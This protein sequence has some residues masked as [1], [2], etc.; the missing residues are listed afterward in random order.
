MSKKLIKLL[1]FFIIPFLVALKTYGVSYDTA[2]SVPFPA[3]I[4]T[5]GDIVS[6][7]N[8]EY[9]LTEIPY[10]PMMVGVIVEDPEVALE[11]RNL[12]NYQFISSYGEVL[13]NVKGDIS[14]GN[15]VTSS[16]IAGVGVRADDNGYVL[17]VALEEFTPANSSDIGQIYIL[18]DIKASFIDNTLSK[19][20]LST[21]KNSLSSP[22]MTPIEAL[23]YLLAIAV[24]FASFVIGFGNFGKITGS[25]VEALGRNPLARG[26][27]RK[28]I[29]FNFILTFMIM[30][31]GVGIA[32]LILT[33]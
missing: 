7:S 17:G 4:G 6:Y 25:S 30:L 2:V 26:A 21:I 19:S 14:E 33:L 28:V 1:V 20:L 3:G 5:G 22:F 8:G 23:R 29:V 13:V 11:D 12:E 10:D 18:L 27:I 31:M 24:I 16:D 9:L 15:Y 32:Y